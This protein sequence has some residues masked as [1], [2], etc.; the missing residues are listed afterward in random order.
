[1]ADQI[2]I[3]NLIKELEGYK[4]HA[5]TKVVRKI[6]ELITMLMDEL[7]PEIPKSRSD[8]LNRG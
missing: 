2:K 5:K 8:S 3:K 7:Y 1:M 6:N 4:P